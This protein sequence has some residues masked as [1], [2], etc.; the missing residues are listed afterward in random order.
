MD[1]IDSY[2]KPWSTVVDLAGAL[3]QYDIQMGLTVGS[4]MRFGPPPSSFPVLQAAVPKDIGQ[5]MT[6]IYNLGIGLH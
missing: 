2:V 1:I 3:E 6:M 5:I 4:G